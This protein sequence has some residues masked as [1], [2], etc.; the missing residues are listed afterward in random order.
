MDKL[1][2]LVPTPVYNTTYPSDQSLLFWSPIMSVADLVMIVGLGA[3]IFTVRWILNHLFFL[4]M[5]RIAGITQKK[6]I[7]KLIENLWYI[8]Y[9][10]LALYFAVTILE[11]ESFFPWNATAY[12]IPFPTY[13]DWADRPLAYFYYMF[14][15]GFYFQG[16]FALFMFETKRKDFLELCIHHFVTILL[17]VFSFCASQHRI[18]LNVL[19]I[20]DISDIL[21]YGTKVVHYFA[22]YGRVLKKP[23]N[24]LTQVSFL[25]FAIAFFVSRNV[26][27]PLY[28]IWPSIDA[29][30]FLNGANVPGNDLMNLAAMYVFPDHDHS[31]TGGFLKQLLRRDLYVYDVER[32]CMFEISHI[33]ACVG[34][35]CFHS[36]IV[37]I[38]MMCVLELLHVFWFIMIIRMILKS[39]VKGK[40]VQQDIRSDD[41]DDEEEDKK[42][43]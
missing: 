29:G 1:A 4:R 25:A 17:I 16:L 22:K 30:I 28:V 3:V 15:L 12:W 19:V 23:L 43:R 11:G 27:Y 14:Q 40:K 36:G 34:A 31:A 21:L 5:A 18:G 42:R 9:Y 10:P 6:V 20:H 38:G 33:G 24:A 8:V 37:L 2:E 41:E 35:H 32:T 39:F 13:S 26:I 7:L